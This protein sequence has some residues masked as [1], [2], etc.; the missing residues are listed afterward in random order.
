MSAL[1]QSFNSNLQTSDLK[2]A[3]KEEILRT[4]ETMETDS[5]EAL[6]ELICEHGKQNDVTDVIP[7]GEEVEDNVL[8]FNLAK[9][10]I[11]LR[12][13]IFKFIKVLNRP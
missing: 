11:P 10:P 6:F 3:E 1:Y 5:M 4:I 2:K 13:I 7:Y 9:M 8:E 12:R